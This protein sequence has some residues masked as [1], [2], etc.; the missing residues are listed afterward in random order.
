MCFIGFGKEFA[1]RLDKLGFTV[2]AGCLS[3]KSEGAKD[4][5]TSTTGKLHVI[6]L[7]ITKDEEV[8]KA[9]AYVTK[10]HEKSGCG[11]F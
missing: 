9:V 1:K 11:M 5:R 4:L 6:G 7:D 10:V 3:D 8:A 2:F